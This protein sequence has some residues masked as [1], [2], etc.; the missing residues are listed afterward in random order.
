MVL[1]A[2]EVGVKVVVEVIGGGIHGCGGGGESGGLG[3]WRR[4]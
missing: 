1:M 3:D 2:V 4:Y